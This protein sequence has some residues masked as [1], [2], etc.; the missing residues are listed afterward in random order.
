M[1]QRSPDARFMGGAWV[2]PGGAVDEGDAGALAR[3]VVRSTD[4]TLLPFRAAAA[5]ELVEETGIWL[6]EGGTIASTGRDSRTKIFAAAAQRNERFAGD[7]MWCFAHWIT[8]VVLPVRFD[9]RFFAAVVPRGIEAVA[10]GSEVVDAAWISPADALSR[11]NAGAWSIA[12]P[13]RRTLAD[14]GAFDAT[15]ALRDHQEAL[16]PIEPVEPRLATMRGVVRV[17]LPGEPGFEAA[18]PSVMAPRER[19][20]IPRRLSTGGATASGVG[21]S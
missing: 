19:A 9:T 7:S 1:V 15:R 10:D 12:F 13:T 6:L 2:F 4:A 21:P 5:R 20:E 11:A 17:L 8:P 14:L 18:D 16:G 3:S